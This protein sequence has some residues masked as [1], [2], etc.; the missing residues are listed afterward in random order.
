MRLVTYVV[1]LLH[2]YVYVFGSMELS[3]SGAI[4]FYR[5]A[6]VVLVVVHGTRSRTH[7][8][9]VHLLMDAGENLVLKQCRLTLRSQRM[10]FFNDENDV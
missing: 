5:P 4:F 6:R 9:T 1:V 2:V 7:A 3:M 10:S 8:S